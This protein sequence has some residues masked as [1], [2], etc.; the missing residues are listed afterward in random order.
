MYTHRAC[1]ARMS[2]SLQ[3]GRDQDQQ[4][5]AIDTVTAITDISTQSSTCCAAVTSSS[6]YLDGFLM[7]SALC[8][9]A[10]LMLAAI[11]MSQPHAHEDVVTGRVYRSHAHHFAWINSPVLLI[12]ISPYS[13]DNAGTRG[14]I[15]ACA[16]PHVDVPV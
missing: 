3:T 12:V 13:V 4:E 1:G 6:K 5:L 11:C 2:Y 14:V 9:S 15:C 16:L 8:R 10:S 7:M